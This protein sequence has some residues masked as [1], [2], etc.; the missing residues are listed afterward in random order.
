MARTR[1]ES[2]DW[3]PLSPKWGYSL[4]LG[5]VAVVIVLRLLIDPWLGERGLFLVFTIPVLLSAVYG[6]LGPALAAAFASAAFGFFAAFRDDRFQTDELIN[7]M[8]FALVAAGIIFVAQRLTRTNLS[9]ATQRRLAAEQSR[10]A[11]ES[12]DELNLF[13][14]AAIDY[15]IFIMDERGRIRIWNRG[16]ERVLGWSEAEA[17]GQSGSVF[18]PPDEVAAGKPD[19]DLDEARAKGALSEICWLVR[20]D[21]SEFLADAT[22]TPL[23]EAG[24][25]MRGFVRVLR[26]VTE[27]HAANRAVQRSER[28]LRSI[29]ETVPDAMVV[30]DERG[31]IISFSAAAEKTFGHSADEVVGRNVRMLMPSPDSERHDSYLDNYL[32]TGE[33]KIIGIGRVVTGLRKEGSTFPMELTVGETTSEG[34]RI[35]TGFVRDLTEKHFSEAR[36][37]ELQAELIHV[38]RLSAMGTMASTL[39]HE[40]NQPLTA[41]TNYAEAAGPLVASDAPDKRELVRDI[42]Q[43]MAA[44]AMRAGAIVHRLREFISRGEVEK[45]VEDVPKL[46]NEAAALALVGARERGVSARF[47]LDPKASPIFADRVQIQQVLINLIRNAVEAMEESPVRELVVA[48]ACGEDDNVILMVSDSGPGLTPEMS[49]QLFHAFVSTKGSGMGLGLSICRTIVE[50]HGGRILY[51]RSDAGGAKFDIVLPRPTLEP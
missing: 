8:L 23:L 49:E 42:F 18:Y 33:R 44:Q 38:D 29:L 36:I 37:Q 14:D 22:L 47:E 15:A 35:F 31:H 13:I 27:V 2:A 41:I 16:A 50:A 48:S 30:I 3:K 5:S 7:I 24:G 19:A 43:D 9:L 46:I 34:Q 10:R 25:T 51:S 6:G 45:R 12:A 40:L 4:A 17:L 32:R 26:D 20:K 11:V 39:A 1:A 28:H 21:G